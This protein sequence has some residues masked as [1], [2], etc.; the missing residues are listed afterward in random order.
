MA[1]IADV[2]SLRV[3]TV[4]PD[5][6]VQLAIA[7]E[8]RGERGPR[9]G[10][11]GQPPRGH[12][13]RARRAA[14]RRGELGVAGAQGRR[15]DDPPRPRRVWP[16]RDDILAA[17]ALVAER[18]IRHLPVVQDGMVMG[19][20]G[21][22]DVTR[23]LLELVWRDHEGAAR[24]RPG[25]C[26]SAPD[27]GTIA[28][29]GRIAPRESAR[30]TRERSVVRIPPAPTPFHAVRGRA[31]RSRPAASTARASSR[32]PPLLLDAVHG[33]GRRGGEGPRVDSRRPIRSSTAREL[34]LAVIVWA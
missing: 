29:P 23:S 31:V 27:A 20:V 24:G 3:L 26:S 6:T 18:R 8:S 21:L 17:G 13:H 22:R 15:R 12:L 2:M 11:R 25:S 14:S 19:I 7:Q 33:R 9:R 32:I 4:T 10:V 16:R 28:A 34:V 1:R 5:V 30:L